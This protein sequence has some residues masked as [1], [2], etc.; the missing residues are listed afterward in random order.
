[1]TGSHW[2]YFTAAYFVIIFIVIICI[3]IV[4]KHLNRS[5]DHDD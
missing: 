5:K 2:L 3:I 1:V 4:K